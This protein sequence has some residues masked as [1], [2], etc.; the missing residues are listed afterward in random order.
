M[1]I[2]FDLDGTL[3]KMDF[4]DAVWLEEIPR[5]Y[6][7]KNGMEFDEAK[8][9][10]EKEYLKVG[11][12][13]IKWYDINYWLNKFDLKVNYKKIFERCRNK[14]QL[15]PEVIDVLEKLD[16]MPLIII[17]NAAME[18]I[19]FEMEELNLNKHFEKV[20]SAVSHFNKTKKDKEVYIEVCNDMEKDC[21]EFIHIGDNYEFDYMAAK[22]AGMNA[23]FL[24]R[25][26]NE[27]GKHVV[28]DLNEFVEVL[29][30]MVA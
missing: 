12:E 3:V 17:S 13:S 5:L 18:F 6:A 11:P 23:F 25:H 27:N 9:V 8:R 22:Q 20:Y 16:D 30:E 29:N 26:R 10:I 2:S 28:W 15:Y 4:V 7:E 14:L 21:S 1:I 24:D 19:E